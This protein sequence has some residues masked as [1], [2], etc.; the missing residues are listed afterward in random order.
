MPGIS[1]RSA[2]N[3]FKTL[4]MSGVF[5]SKVSRLCGELHERVVG[6][7]IGTVFVKNSADASRA[8]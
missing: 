1:T 7:S 5:K 2:N 8:P 6:A 4:G 3:L